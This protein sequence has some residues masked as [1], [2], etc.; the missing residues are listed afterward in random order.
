MAILYDA[1]R[2]ANFLIWDQAYV[3]REEGVIDTANPM[4]PGALV[5][6]QVAQGTADGKPATQNA[7][8]GTISAVTVA[9]TAKAGTYTATFTGATAFT[10]TDPGGTTVATGT[11][12]SAFNNQIGFTITVGDEAFVDG[13]S[14]IITVDITEFNY[15]P[16]ASGDIAGVL[17]EGIS[18]DEIDSGET[19]KR[20]VIARNAEVQLSGLVL[21][22]KT[23][24]EAIEGLNALGI[25]VRIH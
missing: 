23:Q 25:A 5:E 16:I 22:A 12:G 14:F 2:T 3:S 10:V 20:T 18:Q 15:V 4:L 19:L 7:G 13:D 11:T 6:K 9:A 17:F 1:P 24:A 8:D 21:G